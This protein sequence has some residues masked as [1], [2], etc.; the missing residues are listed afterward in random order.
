MK[1]IDFGGVPQPE[2]AR[3]CEHCKFGIVDAPPVVYNVP[4]FWQRAIAYRLGLLNLCE[5]RAGQVQHFYLEE[6]LSEIP[7]DIRFVHRTQD[8][9]PAWNSGE[10][11]RDYIPG[12]WW[13]AVK[14]AA[15]V[16]G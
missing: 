7:T 1:G 2:W 14:E 13:L 16:A 10:P 3:G 5:C 12:A 6:V 11:P 9:L 8:K 4:L 15:E